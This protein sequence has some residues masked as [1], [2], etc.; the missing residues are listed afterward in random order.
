MN[1]YHV[2]LSVHLR[3]CLIIIGFNEILTFF[4]FLQSDRKALLA[5]ETSE[6]I[7]NK[8]AKT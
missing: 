6:K 3:L 4:F 8:S 1:F 2:S 5:V 7:R